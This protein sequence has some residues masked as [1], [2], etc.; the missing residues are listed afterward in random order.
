MQIIKADVGIAKGA[1]RRHALRDQ[2]IQDRANLRGGIRL[3]P[4]AQLIHFRLAPANRQRSSESGQL[5]AKPY[6]TTRESIYADGRSESLHWAL[7]WRTERSTPWRSIRVPCL[8]EGPSFWSIGSAQR[9]I[10]S[11][12]TRPPLS[13]SNELDRHASHA[14]RPISS[15]SPGRVVAR[16]SC[17][18][19]G[20]RAND[21][22]RY[23]L[24][25]LR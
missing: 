23:V 7:G 13:S 17:L 2:R 10:P 3:L 25:P 8:T 1:D 11:A 21:G 4:E 22:R 15:I 5:G 9:T 20:G 16:L 19:A 6:W 18:P 24:V 12:G 14:R